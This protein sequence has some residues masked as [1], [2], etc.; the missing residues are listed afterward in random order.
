MSLVVFVIFLNAHLPFY[1]IEDTIIVSAHFDSKMNFYAPYYFNVSKSESAGRILY[2]NL[3]ILRGLN[4]SSL[5]IGGTSA[6]QNSILFANIY[7]PNAML[8]YT[9]ISLLPLSTIKYFQVLNSSSPSTGLPGIG[10]SVNLVPESPGYF[11]KISTYEKNYDAIIPVTKNLQVGTFLET[12]KDSYPVKIDGISLVMKN[13]GSLKYGVFLLNQKRGNSFFITRRCSGSPPPLGSVGKGYKKEII[14]GLKLSLPIVEDLHL[15]VNQSA[16]YQTY[17]TSYESD[18]HFVANTR[19]SAEWNKL[20]IGLSKD[21]AFST[22]IGNKQKTDYIVTVRNVA[23]PIRHL[24]FHPSLTL[25]ATE[26]VDKIITAP[27]ISISRCISESF[28]VFSSISRTYRLPT[29]NEL[30]WPED[31]FARGNPALKPESGFNLDT[32]FRLFK[33]GLYIAGTMYLKK[34]KNAIMWVQ[35]DKYAPKNF[36]D[37]EHLGSNITFS[38]FREEDLGGEI[39]FNFQRSFL[40]RL[41]YLYRPYFSLSSLFLTKFLKISFTYLGKRP[42]RPNSTKTLAPVYLI[43]VSIKRNFSVKGNLLEFSIGIENLLGKN[44]ILIPGYPQPGRNFFTE[45]RLKGGS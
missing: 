28:F 14:E 7:L 13:T 19:V 5:S 36:A 34:V 37:G 45:I 20:I 16:F 32:G 6:E 12:F 31:A 17:S 23:I 35:G 43:D 1:F 21:L 11:L 3:L 18:T 41:P 38:Y 15:N 40:N 25:I 44:Y 30:Y 22:K 8:G 27:G 9:D 2:S 29:F 33:G 26:N 10:G 24:L 4:Y 42:E 39:N